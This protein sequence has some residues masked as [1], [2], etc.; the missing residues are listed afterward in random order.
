MRK[1]DVKKLLS[2]LSDLQKASGK[3]AAA[4]EGLWDSGDTYSGYKVHRFIDDIYRD[5]KDN[6][7]ALKS[8]IDLFVGITDAF[9]EEEIRE[10]KKLTH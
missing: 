8:R 9:T 2:A 4:S 7:R 6:T 3:L 1:V 5:N 10:I